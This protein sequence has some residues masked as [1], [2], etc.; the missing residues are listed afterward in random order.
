M[1]KPWSAS[2][3]EVEGKE[4]SIRANCI[5]PTQ[6]M[7]ASCERAWLYNSLNGMV[8]KVAWWRTEKGRT[9]TRKKRDYVH[10]MHFPFRA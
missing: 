4:D 9:T 8:L 2:N 10:I 3:L 5:S 1:E 6:E 7:S